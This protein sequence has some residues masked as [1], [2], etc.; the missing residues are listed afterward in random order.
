M[1]LSAKT[2]ARRFSPGK[3]ILSET[4]VGDDKSAPSS[5][6]AGSANW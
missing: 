1:K 6:C 2:E 4:G 3:G 5:A